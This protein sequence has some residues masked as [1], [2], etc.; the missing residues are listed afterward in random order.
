MPPGARDRGHITRM[1]PCSVTAAGFAL[2][3]VLLLDKHGDYRPCLSLLAVRETERL[4]RVTIAGFLL[5]LPILLAVTKSIPR[6]AIALA[7]VTVPLLL[8]LEKWQVQSA[9]QM[10]A[11]L[12]SHHAQGGDPGDRHIGTQHFLHAGAVAEVRARSRGVRRDRHHHHGAGDLRSVVSAQTPGKRA[13]RPVTPKLL[14][15]LEASVLIIAAPEISPEETAE[16][17]IAGRGSG[18]EHVLHSAAVS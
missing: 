1:M 12:G 4:L 3:M 17:D 7:L 14:R 6:T 13:A 16:I 8:A 5:A 18:H 10:H 11:G 2:L 15:R 9:I